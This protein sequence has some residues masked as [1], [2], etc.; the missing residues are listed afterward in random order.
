MNQEN[1][2]LS[3][4]KQKRAGTL[5]DIIYCYNFVY[6]ALINCFDNDIKDNEDIK[7]LVIN[8]TYL[9]ITNLL[10]P[11]TSNDVIVNMVNR[12]N[13]KRKISYDKLL[14]DKPSLYNQLTENSIYEETRA[15][16]KGL[17]FNLL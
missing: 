1:E 12:Y 14:A 4:A 6:Q 8:D 5:E 17:M 13:D 16:L 7:E 10:I 3:Y 2:V 9:I 15:Y 11:I